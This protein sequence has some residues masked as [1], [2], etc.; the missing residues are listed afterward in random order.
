MYIHTYIHTIRRV[1]YM[2]TK[3]DLGNYWTTE[4]FEHKKSI[5]QW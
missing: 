5:L 1:Y 2:I 4:K 3:F